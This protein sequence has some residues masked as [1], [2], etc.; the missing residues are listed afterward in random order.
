MNR[1]L[2]LADGLGLRNLLAIDERWLSVNWKLRRVDQ[3]FS[4]DK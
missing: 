3:K 4:H 2:G 1:M